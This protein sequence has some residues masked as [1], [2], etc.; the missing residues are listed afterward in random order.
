MVVETV[1]TS[2]VSDE[3]WMSEGLLL[4]RRAGDE[5]PE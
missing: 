3:T 5:V 4:V 1:E 2:D